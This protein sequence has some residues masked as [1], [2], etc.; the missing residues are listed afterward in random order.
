MFLF[1]FCCS[2]KE[3]SPWKLIKGQGV[4]SGGVLTYYQEPSSHS[5]NPAEDIRAYLYIF[6]GSPC[7]GC[8]PAVFLLPRQTKHSS[9]E[10]AGAPSEFHS[11]FPGSHRSSKPPVFLPLWVSGPTVTSFSVSRS[12]RAGG[13]G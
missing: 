10:T 11:L 7:V 8:C 2:R 9:V 5:V 6:M 4:T 1:V 12:S 13:A 3:T